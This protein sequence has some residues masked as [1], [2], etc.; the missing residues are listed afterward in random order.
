MAKGTTMKVTASKVKQNNPVAGVVAFV[1]ALL[2]I[3]PLV[4]CLLTSFLTEQEI[5][6][7]KVIPTS[8]YVGNYQKALDQAPLLQTAGNLGKGPLLK[9]QQLCQL[10]GV[11]AR[12]IDNGL[13]RVDLP[14]AELKPAAVISALRIN[15]PV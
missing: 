2:I 15:Y 8:F 7:L 6:Q 1:F 10:R 4:Y 13:Q 3:S 12:V 14:G 11:Q 5:F 9:P